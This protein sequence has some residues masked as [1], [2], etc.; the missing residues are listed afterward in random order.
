M[1]GAL[2]TGK[3]SFHPGKQ[4][5][6]ND[7]DSGVD[8]GRDDG[9]KFDSDDEE[10]DDDDVQVIETPSARTS[11]AKVGISLSL[12]L[13]FSPIFFFPYLSLLLH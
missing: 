3:T 12:S 7:S 4:L 5:F 13:L 9:L 10:D 8:S 6:N 1:H 11:I 2:A